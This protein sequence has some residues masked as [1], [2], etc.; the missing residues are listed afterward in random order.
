MR[1]S[2]SLVLPVPVLRV[3]EH[4]FATLGNAEIERVQ[5]YGLSRFAC[6]VSLTHRSQRALRTLIVPHER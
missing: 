3:L 6:E 4:S 2:P 5:V 1:L